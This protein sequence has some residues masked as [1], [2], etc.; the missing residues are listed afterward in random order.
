M[1]EDSRVETHRATSSRVDGDAIVSC[2][3]CGT[4]FHTDSVYRKTAC[5]P[6]CDKI[7]AMVSKG[8]PLELM[9]HTVADLEIEYPVEPCNVVLY[10]PNGT[11]KSSAA[12]AL[13]KLWGKQAGWLSAYGIVSRIKSTFRRAS[14]ESEEDVIRHIAS[15]PVFVVDDLGAQHGSEFGYATLYEIIKTRCEAR[16]PTI[17]TTNCT[18]V[19]IDEQ[20]PRLASRLSAFV[21]MPMDGRD[22]R[23]IG[24]TCKRKR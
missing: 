3:Y 1:P 9:R 16:R 10:G 23:G 13:A 5:S 24:K 6:E 19:E 8:F 22:R 11:G 4:P 15:F 2:G 12:V 20:D 14:Q 18:I 17:V 7:L 21:R